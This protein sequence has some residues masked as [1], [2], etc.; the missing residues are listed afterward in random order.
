METRQ[1]NYSDIL[2][3][4]DKSK[5]IGIETPSGTVMFTDDRYK[6]QLEALIQETIA[7]YLT[8]DG[9][10]DEKLWKD[11]LGNDWERIQAKVMAVQTREN[12]VIPKFNCNIKDIDYLFTEESCLLDRAKLIKKYLRTYGLAV[13]KYNK[14][15]TLPYQAWD[16]DPVSGAEAEARGFS[17]NRSKKSIRIKESKVSPASGIYKIPTSIDNIKV[18]RIAE[19]LY[20]PYIKQVEIPSTVEVLEEAAF[21]HCEFSQIELPASLKTIGDYAFCS[22][23]I[24]SLII[25]DS[26]TKIGKSAFSNC[27]NLKKITLSK[28]LNE[29]SSAMFYSCTELKRLCIPDAVTTICN[30]AFADCHKLSSV[31]IPKSVICIEDS[32]FQDCSSLS[33]E[34][35][36]TVGQ[37][38]TQCCSGI[39]HLEYHGPLKSSA[40]FGAQTFN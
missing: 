30:N 13:L 25:P 10:K 31:Y 29:I 16:T 19:C 35:P 4:V 28:N 2:F 32:C 22:C 6:K 24:E 18:E 27:R 9:L 38:A 17:F 1:S 39:R 20:Y 11:A 14:A 36:D 40:H 21:D 37:I 3:L 5:I 7:P 23:S 12:A 26:V 15:S 8:P 34:I 33:L